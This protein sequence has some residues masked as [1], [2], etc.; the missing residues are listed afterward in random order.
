MSQKT[1]QIASAPEGIT[2]VMEPSPPD[3]EEY[4][5]VFCMTAHEKRGEK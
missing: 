4:R 3:F 2:D 5:L 1:G